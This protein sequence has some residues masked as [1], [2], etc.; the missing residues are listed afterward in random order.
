MVWTLPNAYK[1]ISVCSNLIDFQ[2][3]YICLTVYPWVLFICEFVLAEIGFGAK[4]VLR[5]VCMEI[6]ETSNVSR[7]RR[8]LV[9]H[10]EI[11]MENEDCWKC[12]VNYPE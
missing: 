9:A 1:P 12:F 4:Y 3:N 8:Y 6:R 5:E 2:V 11:R 10:V 7:H